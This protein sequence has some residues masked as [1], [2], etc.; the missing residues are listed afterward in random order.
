M[1]IASMP[2]WIVLSIYGLFSYGPPGIS[3]IWQTFIVAVFSG[4]IATILYFYATELVQHD[5]Y[6]LA[7]VEST[8]T[9]AVLFVLIAVL[10]FLNALLPIYISFIGIILIINIIIVF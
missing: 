6:K 7:G 9:M 8:V 4:V 1:T 2:F 5:N 3:Q 10:I